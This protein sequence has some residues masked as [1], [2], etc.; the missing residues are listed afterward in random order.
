MVFRSW[1]RISLLVIAICIA[2]AIGED[3]L[4]INVISKPDDC[5]VF[6]KNG[7]NL[8]MHYSGYIDESSASGKRGEMF[9]S[10]YKRKKPL[11]FQLGAGRVI[12]GWD[13]GVLGM[14]PG[15]KRV[16]IIPPELGYGSR[17]AGK[18]IPG[19]ATLRFDIELIGIDGDESIEEAEEEEMNLFVDMDTNKDNKVSYDEMA[20]WFVANHPNGR[21]GMPHMFFEKQDKNFDTLLSWEEFDGPKGKSAPKNDEL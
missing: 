9:D 6:A 15:E 1:I 12:Q 7:D 11:P 3:Q 20:D 4:K 19:G 5:S 14:C 16:L 18:A 17:G 21:E 13:K 2:C 10:S 8:K